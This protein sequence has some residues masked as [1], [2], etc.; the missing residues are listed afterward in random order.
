M[1]SKPLFKATLKQNRFVFLIIL[2][3]MMLYLP[4]IISMY[5]PSS[6]D[7][8]KE[9]MNLLPK[10]VTSAFGFSKGS[11]TLL[12]FIATYYY[13]FLILLLPMIYTIIVSNRSLASHVDR[14]SMAYLLSTPNTRVKIA[15]TQACYLILSITLLISLV[16]LA[17]IAFCQLLFPGKLDLGGFI[18]LNFGALLLYY[19]T[20]GIGFFASALFNE[21]KNSLAVGAGLPIAFLILQMLSNVG[22]ATKFFKYLTLY[23]LFDTE[24]IISG[25]SFIYSYLLLATI[26]VVLYACAILVFKKRDLPL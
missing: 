24:K 23:T 13:G 18:A 14:G 21:T 11:N 7:S 5:D 10:Q 2:A 8:L 16:T 20:T 25:G 19:A 17:G 26:G 12:G 15:L 4:T 3:V 1:I 6:Q 22:D 9:M